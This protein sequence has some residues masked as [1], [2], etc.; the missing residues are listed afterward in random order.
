MSGPLRVTV[1]GVAAWLAVGM[2]LAAADPGAAVAPARAQVGIGGIYRTGAWT[3]VV[4]STASGTAA[5]GAP[6]ASEAPLHV[7][8]EDPD[9]QFVRAPAGAVSASTQGTTTARFCVRCGRPEAVLL[10][11]TSGAEGRPHFARL[12]LPAP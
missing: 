7:W 12:S 3:P 5:P 1:A 8:A 11:E 9:G 4:I 10:L 2:P 6:G